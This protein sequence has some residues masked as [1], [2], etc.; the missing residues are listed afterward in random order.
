MREKRSVKWSLAVEGESLALAAL[1]ADD[2]T[3]QLVIAHGAVGPAITQVVPM[4]AVHSVSAP[5]QAWT[6]QVCTVLL[7]P[8]TQTVAAR[9]CKAIAMAFIKF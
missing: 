7:I 1:W 6:L 9:P 3:Q 2:V 4:Q 5:K 8:P